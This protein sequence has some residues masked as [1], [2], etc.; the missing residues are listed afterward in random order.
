MYIF[1]MLSFI[2][3]QVYIYIIMIIVIIIFIFTIKFIFIFTKSESSMF[4]VWLIVN[5][6]GPFTASTYFFTIQL[7][8]V[9]PFWASKVGPTT[10]KWGCHSTYRGYDYNAL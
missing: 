10:C 1:L 3:I 8:D 5:L 9:K 2:F 6:F 7:V 4:F